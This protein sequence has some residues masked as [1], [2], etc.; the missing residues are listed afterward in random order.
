MSDEKRD[1][2]V[3]W[4]DNGRGPRVVIDIGGESI[5][6][7]PDLARGLRDDLIE[8][9]DEIAA[10]ANPSLSPIADAGKPCELGGEE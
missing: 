3:T 2:R 10:S 1:R 6:T 9:L 7:T 8:V 4:R 5:V